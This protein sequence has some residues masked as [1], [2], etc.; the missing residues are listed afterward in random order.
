[1]DAYQVGEYSTTHL[2]NSPLII[3][4]FEDTL[5]ECLDPKKLEYAAMELDKALKIE[6]ACKEEGVISHQLF[7][8]LMGHLES[9]EE[10]L[11]QAGVLEHYE[12]ALR[13]CEATAVDLLD[14]E[15][16]GEVE[17][18]VEDDVEDE[19]DEEEFP[20]FV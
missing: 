4:A 5:N 13:L 7:E 20:L 15:A 12:Y 17:L 14:V 19:D 11:N 6:E 16:I 2:S 8:Q 9:A 1:M 10:L 18:H 3:Q